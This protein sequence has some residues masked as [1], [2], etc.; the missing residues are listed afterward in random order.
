MSCQWPP[1]SS[2][3][4]QPRAKGRR[5]KRHGVGR[6]AR[7]PIEQEL[8]APAPRRTP[9]Q[10]VDDAAHRARAVE[11]GRHALDDLDLA[12]IHRR[13]LQQPKP[14][15]LAKQRQPVRQHARV[16]ASHA[17]NAHAGRAERRRRRL[18]AHAAHFVQ[19]HDDVA[20]RHEHLLFDLLAR[21][22]LDAHGLIL[23][24]PVGARRRDD[25]DALFDGRLR[26]ELDDQIVHLARGDRDGH[27]HGRKARLDDRQIARARRCSHRPG[28]GQVGSMRYA[29]DDHLGV[30]DRCIRSAHLDAHGP[31]GALADEDRDRP[32]HKH[33]E[34]QQERAQ[35][36]LTENVLDKSGVA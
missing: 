30:R 1:P 2:E 28:T 23:E 36:L 9:R 32:A 16:P 22:H 11:R 24:P 21:Q 6:A 17:L 18:H 26:L 20:G 13:D 29:R 27:G 31:R 10:E 34:P 15:D 14:A 3:P 19:H 12:E 25:G 35:E 5:E 8:L 4:L 33:I 7:G